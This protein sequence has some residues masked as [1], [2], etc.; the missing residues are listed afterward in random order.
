[1]EQPRLDLTET[2][3][4]VWPFPLPDLVLELPT[5]SSEL[6]SQETLYTP[7]PSLAR[8]LGNPT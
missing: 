1:M 4:P 7:T 6:F 8:P 2:P 3:R 5:G